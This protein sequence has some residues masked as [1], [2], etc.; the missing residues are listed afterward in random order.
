MMLL[1]RD[2]LLKL[3]LVHQHVLLL[4]DELVLGVAGL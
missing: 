1:R 2:L 3:S 4:G